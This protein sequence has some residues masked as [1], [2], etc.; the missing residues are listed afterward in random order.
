MTTG[1]KVQRSPFWSNDDREESGQPIFP[2]FEPVLP[3]RALTPRSDTK[4]RALFAVRVRKWVPW[5]SRLQIAS[6]SP[7]HTSR[8]RLVN[9]R[10]PQ[11]LVPHHVL[12][13]QF[14]CWGVPL[15]TCPPSVASLAS[16][17]LVDDLI[18]ESPGI[19]S[20]QCLLLV[21]CV[22][23]EGVHF[24]QGAVG[25]VVRKFHRLDLL[26]V[27]GPS[28][29]VGERLWNSVD[30]STYTVLADDNTVTPRPCKAAVGSMCHHAS[31]LSDWSTSKLW[32]VHHAPRYYFISWRFFNYAK[33]RNAAFI[34]ETPKVL[35]WCLRDER[36]TQEAAP[37]AWMSLLGTG[38]D[39]PAVVGSS[40]PTPRWTWP[41]YL[42]ADNANP[43]ETWELQHSPRTVFAPAD[44][45]LYPSWWRS[46]CPYFHRKEVGRFWTSGTKSHPS[47]IF[48]HT[49]HDHLTGSAVKELD[50]GLEGSL[51]WSRRSPPASITW[52]WINVS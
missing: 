29:L 16:L 12:F 45:P 48:G 42:S 46:S 17:I 21:E 44:P 28:H 37:Q 6:S 22:I 13:Q 7:I 25:G 4:Y 30:F 19:P 9:T 52:D 34:P 20:L 36:C 11:L 5:S 31:E 24:W 51:L 18:P 43:L 47:R 3:T 41:A 10:Q 15:Q 1:T 27:N 49:N 40:L 2:F 35:L 8:G 38:F 39:C 26:M 32:S 33:S 23:H 50:A 14:V